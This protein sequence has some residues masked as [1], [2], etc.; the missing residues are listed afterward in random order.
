MSGSDTKYLRA[1]VVLM[2]ELN[3]SRAATKLN[4]GQSALSKQIGHL[5]EHLGYELFVR[6][7]RK[8]TATAA[9]EVYAAEARLSLLHAERAVSL[10]RAAN[11]NSEIILHVGKS[12]YTDPYLITNVLSLRLPFF[13]NLSVMLTSKFAVDLSHDLLNGTLDLAFLTGI[14]ETAQISAVSVAKQSFFVVMLEQD[15]LSQSTEITADQLRVRSC[16]LFDRHVHP[17]LYDLSLIHI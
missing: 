13:P 5:H 9:G 15:D 2:E 3:F 17:Y 6:E 1:A 12:P 10:S 16:V 7:G 4:I 14:P 11:Q 8:I